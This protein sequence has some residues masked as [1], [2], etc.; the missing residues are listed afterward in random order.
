MAALIEVHYLPSLEYFCCLMS[1][2][3]IRLEAHEHFVKQTYRNRCYIR[4]A[5]N[6]QML[7]IPVVKGRSKTSIRDLQTDNRQPWQKLHWRSLKSA[8]GNAPFFVFYEPQLQ[9]HFS[10]NVK[11]LVD[12]TYPLLTLCLEWIGIQP[13]MSWTTMY[14]KTPSSTIS[15]LRSVISAKTHYSERPFYEPVSYPQVFGKNFVP[16]LSIVD[17]LSCEGPNAASVLKRSARV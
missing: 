14:E 7:N 5:N 6:V 3:K 13:D 11:Y 17:L 12:F 15:D 8:Y 9:K 2:G 1:R 10:R 16:N 4:G